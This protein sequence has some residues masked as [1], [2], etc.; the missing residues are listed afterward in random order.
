MRK[1]TLIGLIVCI[2]VIIVFICYNYFNVTE[3][4]FEICK[5]LIAIVSIVYVYKE[6]E[7]HKR[8]EK[9]QVLSSYNER[10]CNDKNIKIVT[11]Y[12]IKEDEKKMPTLYE[13]ELFMRFFEELEIS[14][15]SGL[16]DENIAC[17]MFSYYAIAFS[18]ETNLKGKIKDYDEEWVYFN[19]FIKRLKNIRE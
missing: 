6:Y 17:K 9:T 8:Q 10:L 15:Q 1:I 2:F 16:L 11:E 3:I 5:L 14:I 13:I 7:Q 12:L 19:N 4:G 18:Q